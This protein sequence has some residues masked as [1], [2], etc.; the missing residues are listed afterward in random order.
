MNKKKSE[1]NQVPSVESTEIIEASFVPMSVSPRTDNPT[2][3]IQRKNKIIL[4]THLANEM[5][6]K[7]KDSI[8]ILLSSNGRDLYLTKGSVHESYPTVEL[9]GDKNNGLSFQRA[10]VAKML[11]K[12]LRLSD[13]KA[14]PMRVRKGAFAQKFNI[15]GD[16]VTLKVWLVITPKPDPLYKD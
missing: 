7:K 10:P 13:D 2:I 15:N 8:A 1:A 6:L 9:R 4:N 3:S 11:R 5:E 16:V 14:H 12:R